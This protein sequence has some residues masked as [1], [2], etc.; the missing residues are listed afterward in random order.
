[1]PSFKNIKC[2]D[3]GESA[4]DYAAYGRTKHWQELRQK[5]I[6]LY[7]GECQRCH[8]IIGDRA[9]VHHKTYKRLGKEDI[10]DLTL[11][12]CK[13]H[14]IVHKK[15]QDTKDTTATVMLLLREMSDEEKNLTIAYMRSLRA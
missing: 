11:Y 12:C 5:V 13:C 3:T 6:E 14:K 7:G 8:D 1:M 10:K 2:A 9:N 4:K 15:R